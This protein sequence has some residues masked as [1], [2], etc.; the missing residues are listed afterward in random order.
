[1]FPEVN[2]QPLIPVGFDEFTETG[3]YSLEKYLQDFL[4]VPYE[5]DGQ[6]YDRMT[7]VDYV[8]W[9]KVFNEANREGLLA[10]D[11]FIDKRSQMEEKMAQGRYFAMLYQ[12]TDVAAQQQILYN[13]DPNSIYVAVDG[14]KNSNGD[15]HTLPGG[16]IQ[17]WTVTMISKNCK[18]PDRAIE[19]MSY[20]MSEHGQKMVLLGPEGVTYDM[21]IYLYRMWI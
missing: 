8:E 18:R 17:G 19:L 21:G 13:N 11:V 9:L 12:R 14:P 6:F 4:A 10:N 2:G 1:M 5:K 16:G 20:L 7:D 15:D 3:N